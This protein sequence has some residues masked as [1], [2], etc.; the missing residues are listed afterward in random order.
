[1]AV[2]CGV[3]GETAHLIRNSPRAGGGWTGPRYVCSDKDCKA[4]AAA[5]QRMDRWV[6]TTAV[7]NSMLSDAQSTVARCA[8]AVLPPVDHPAL[9]ERFRSCNGKVTGLDVDGAKAALTYLHE[10]LVR[11]RTEDALAGVGKSA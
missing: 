9:Y 8:D 4:W 10:M 1:M 11:K 6:A 5:E 3:C 7:R 2:F